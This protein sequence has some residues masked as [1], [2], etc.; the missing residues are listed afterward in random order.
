[1]TRQN[2][3]DG[4]R[5][6]MTKECPTCG[7][8][9]IVISEHTAAV[10]I[11]RRLRMLPTPGSRSKAFKVEVAAKVASLIA[12]PGASR[13][14]ELEETTKRVFF[15]VG[16]E[17]EHLDHFRVL[18]QGTLEKVAPKVPVEVGQELEV[19]L[20]EVGLHDQHAGAG[21]VEDID[22]VVG[23][24]A[25]LVG[26]R[27][28]VR[29]TAITEGMAWAELLTPVTP[30]DDPLTAESEAEKPTRAKRP[31][32]RKTEGESELVDGDDDEPEL[33]DSEPDEIEL[34]DADID[35]AEELDDT[36]D[37]PDAV[38]AE[39]A[40]G[41]P[42]GPAKKRTRRG[43]RGGRNRKKPAG[44]PGAAAASANGGEAAPEAGLVVEEAVE[45]VEAV[46]AAEVDAED[47]PD[48]DAPV[49]PVIHVPGR[50]LG[51]AEDGDG[52][53]TTAKK[54]TRRGS[55]GGKNRRKKPLVAGEAAATELL[56]PE[57]DARAD[58]GL[59]PDFEPAPADEREPER[60]LEPEQEPERASRPEPELPSEN[61]DG[62]WTYTPM[63]EWDESS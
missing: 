5:E 55:R 35:E 41:A 17:G 36:V 12:G 63:S 62:E 4:P 26:K 23:D 60:S 44:A 37:D 19:K 21:K 22:V 14:R 1:M 33:D 57:S 32:T 16:K 48:E 8:D 40:A 51:E 61:G 43:T 53:A 54:R 38:G 10:D 34:D 31:S 6:I 18:D 7:G 49:G 3:T 30:G 56:D 2:V 27:V 29:I 13:L 15:L 25:T 46:A 9:G 39:T 52:T 50:E 47:R 45:T 28:K 42:G 58:S 11:E 20:G 24:A 59:E